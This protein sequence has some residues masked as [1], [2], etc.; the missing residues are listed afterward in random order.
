[1][2]FIFDFYFQKVVNIC[3]GPRGCNVALWA[4]WQRHAGPRGSATRAYAV[5]TIYIIYLYYIKGV[6]S[7]P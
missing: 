5:Y 1:M 3:A 7:L 4:T 2:N 6:F